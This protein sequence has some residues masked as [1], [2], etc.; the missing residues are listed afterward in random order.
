MFKYLLL[1][2]M[3]YFII[4]WAFMMGDTLTGYS[5]PWLDKTAEKMANIGIVILLIFVIAFFSVFTYG[6]V[7]DDP[8][9]VEA[10]K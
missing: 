10:I 8:S 2:L 6:V 7:T 5:I 3:I 4:M 9:F 1:V